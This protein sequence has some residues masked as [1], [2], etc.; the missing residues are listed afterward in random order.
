ME[1]IIEIHEAVENMTNF[2]VTA[3]RADDLEHNS[4]LRT[5]Q[6]GVPIPI[7]SNPNMD[8]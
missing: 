6:P 7:N 5:I 8:K 4:H 1:L 3:V 2:T